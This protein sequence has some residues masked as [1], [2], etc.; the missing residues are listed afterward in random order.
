[1]N[2]RVAK[3]LYTVYISSFIRHC[4]ARLAIDRRLTPQTPAPQSLRNESQSSSCM[5]SRGRSGTVQRSALTYYAFDDCQNPF[6]HGIS[7][8]PHTVGGG[9]VQGLSLL[10]LLRARNS[11][12]AKLLCCQLSTPIKVQQPS[13]A[14]SST[15]SVHRGGTFS[16]IL[17]NHRSY[18]IDRLWIAPAS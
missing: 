7:K 15:R 12:R 5:W 14:R 17:P 6:G 1:M 18:V 10:V 3:D 11:R 16:S 8:W 4:A 9:S 2:S 13:L